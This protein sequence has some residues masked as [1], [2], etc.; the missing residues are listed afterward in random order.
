[1][2]VPSLAAI[3]AKLGYDPVH[4]GVVMVLAI[5]LGAVVPPVATLLFI[6]CSIAKIPLSAIMRLVWLFLVPLVL[7]TFLIAYI[8]PLVTAIPRLFFQ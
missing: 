3:G 5:L 1:M 6:G 8:P 4:F 2:F 7:V